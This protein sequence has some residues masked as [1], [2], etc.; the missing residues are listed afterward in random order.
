MK[1]PGIDKPKPIGLWNARAI[2]LIQQRAEKEHRS[3]S[4]SLT[5]TVIEHLSSEFGTQDIAK[6]DNGQ[7]ATKIISGNKE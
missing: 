4:N 6:N 1:N 3:L 2:L 5:A 7:V